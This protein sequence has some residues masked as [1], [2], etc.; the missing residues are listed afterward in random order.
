MYVCN[1]LQHSSPNGCLE[2]LLEGQGMSHSQNS[3]KTIYRH[4]RRHKNHICN[5]TAEYIPEVNCTLQ[6]NFH[7]H[8]QQTPRS[9]K[10]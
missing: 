2:K 3:L 8:T 5:R 10:Q 9:Q 6:Q 1:F 7:Q 4:V